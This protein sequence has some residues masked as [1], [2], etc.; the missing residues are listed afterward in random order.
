MAVGPGYRPRSPFADLGPHF[1]DVVEPARFPREVLR[2]RNQRA[3]S[4][5]G[6]DAL[7]AAQWSAHFA[8]FEPLPG[9]QSEPRAIRYHGHQ[10]DHYNPDLGDGRGFLFAQLVDERGR[11]LDLGTKGSGTTPWSRGGDGRLTLKGGVREVLATELLEAL[12]VYTSRSLSLFETG[13]QL[14]R[15]DE[16]SPTR[17]SVLVRLSH[18]HLRIGVFQRQHWEATTLGDPRARARI[19][20]LVTY[21]RRELFPEL[22]ADPDPA[23]AL[24][25]EVTRR[26]AGL[27][28]SWQ[29]A[30]FVHG[31]L[32]SDNH[33]LTAESFD[34][35]PWRFLPHLDPGFT[36]AYFDETGLYSY[37]RQP[38]AVL[39][40]LLRFAS[41]LEGSS[42]RE[43]RVAAV[44]GFGA[45]LERALAERTLARLG[46]VSRGWDEDTRLAGLVSAWLESSR[47]PWD[48]FW[49]DWYGGALSAS[50]SARS[51]SAA[52]YRSEGFAPLRALL[53]EFEARDPERL[54]LPYFARTEPCT[55]VIDEVERI[56]AHIAERDDWSA[57]EAKVA[58]IREL[59]TALALTSGYERPAR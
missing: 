50:R 43:A 14:L 53:G 31:V 49:F 27:V 10:F 13:E 22:D 26:S 37:A 39:N 4:S 56:W 58:D 41:S 19:D 40:N 9:A 59:G 42:P 47:A 18:S 15:H 35:G 51:P 33:V 46:L 54:A 24:L 55:L 21:A 29:I 2:F 7:G 48:A 12:G 57:F 38:R 25:R 11:L 5:V 36:A 8:R 6:L 32:N 23:S 34:Y 44:S 20:E 52:H 3:A 28:A 1:S 16:P 30:G 17:S 45:E